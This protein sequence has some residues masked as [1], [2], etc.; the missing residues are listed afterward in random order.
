MRLTRRELIKLAAAAG[1]GVTVLSP[2][3]AA[4]APAAAA[5]Q[6]MAVLVDTARCI[7]CRLC[8]G[9]CKEYHGFPA[10]ESSDL[11]PKAW[12]YVRF[13]T[14]RQPLDHLNLG[15]EG[16]PRRSYKVQCLNCVEPACASACPVA[17]L[18]KTPEG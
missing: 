12:T 15:A 14:L 16:A 2:R 7:G 1:L 18:R 8:E 10:G 13:R 6:A 11:A 3:Q 4:A 5:P 9:A 17:A